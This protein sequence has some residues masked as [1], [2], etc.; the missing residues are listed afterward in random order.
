MKP[1]SLTVW[2]EAI[3]HP[4]TF[5]EKLK[6]FSSAS[7]RKS[8]SQKGC[9]AAFCGTDST[10]L[11]S[12]QEKPIYSSAVRPVGFVWICSRFAL[13]SLS[14][15][16]TFKDIRLTIKYTFIMLRK[17]KPQRLTLCQ[18]VIVSPEALK[19]S[20]QHSGRGGKPGLRNVQK[21]KYC[22]AL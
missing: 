17:S 7:K 18:H 6:L 13:T 12:Q 15:E 14:G 5:S 9:Q 20:Y 8:L 2:E 4:L 3:S 11:A 21:N 1:P 19:M 16:R 22:M 10:R